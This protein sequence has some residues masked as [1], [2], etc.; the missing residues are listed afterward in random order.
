MIKKDEELK[1]QFDEEAEKVQPDHEKIC[2]LIRE[3]NSILHGT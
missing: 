1:R 2:S 3:A